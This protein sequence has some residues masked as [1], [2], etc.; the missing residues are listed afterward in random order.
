MSPACLTCGSPLDSSAKLLPGYTVQRCRTCRTF[1]F[2]GDTV[3]I[4]AGDGMMERLARRAQEL[5][6]L[7]VDQEVVT[8]DED[9]VRWERVG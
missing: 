9:D 7:R 1:G 2:E 8:S 5:D 4:E 6:A 3:R